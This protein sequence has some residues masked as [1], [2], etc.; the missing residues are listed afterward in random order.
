MRHPRVIMA[1]I[2]LAA[3]AAVGGVTA[4]AATGSPASGTPPTASASASVAAAGSGGAATVH[5]AQATVGGRTE[6]ILVNAHGLPLYYYRPDTATRSLVSGGLAK[7]WP[8][9]TSSGPTAA[10]GV[11]G[12][13]AV[14]R[15]VHGDQVAYNGHPLY[16]FIGDRPGRVS[17]QDV[18]GFLVATPGIAPI[19]A[20][21]ASPG[22]VPAAPSGG[23]YGY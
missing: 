12:K 16:T 11:G 13:L 14:V 4:A 17:G 5:T 1:G 7:L 2:G 21:A 6:A 19:A 10:A 8:P 18:Q 15:D 20:S 9:L 23:G 22:A 3:V